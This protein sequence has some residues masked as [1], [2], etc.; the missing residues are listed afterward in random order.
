MQ[1]EL[2]VHSSRKARADKA[3]HLMAI[4]IERSVLPI[5]EEPVEGEDEDQWDEDE[6]VIRALALMAHRSAPAGPRHA[7]SPVAQHHG[8]RQG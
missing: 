5:F 3:Y 7:R 6:M 1:H 4:L 2:G 8:A